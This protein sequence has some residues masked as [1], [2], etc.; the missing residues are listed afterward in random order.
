MS[1][2]LLEIPHIRTFEKPHTTPLNQLP[3]FACH[4]KSSRASIDNHNRFLSLGESRGDFLYHILHD[5]IRRCSSR[6]FRSYRG[7]RIH[8]G[9][10]CWSGKGSGCRF[11]WRGGMGMRLIEEVSSCPVNVHG[12]AL[13]GLV[14]N[15]SAD[16]LW[17]TA[18]VGISTYPGR[19]CSSTSRRVLSNASVQVVGVLGGIS[20][21]RHCEQDRG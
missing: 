15:P 20:L 8:L 2:R 9:G 11:R 12:G 5:F 17:C 6:C 7:D 3:H 1:F 10:G 19:H 13:T 4:P 16:T 18:S 14:F 21:R